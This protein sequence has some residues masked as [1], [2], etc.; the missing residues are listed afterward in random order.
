MKVEIDLVEQQF[1]PLTAKAEWDAAQSAVVQQHT[2]DLCALC[3]ADVAEIVATGGGVPAGQAPHLRS[4]V[5]WAAVLS[6]KPTRQF[7]S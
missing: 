5:S 2:T 3:C 6:S 1:T 7:S 4:S